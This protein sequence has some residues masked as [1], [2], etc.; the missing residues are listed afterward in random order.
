M[1]F[2]L[3]QRK[4][5]PLFGIAAA[6]VLGLA[7]FVGV[8]AAFDALNKTSNVVA[9]TVSGALYWF[10]YDVL[11]PNV[12]TASVANAGSA[13]AV[14]VLLYHGEGAASTAM[15][16]SVF[17]AQL[18]ALK[19]DGW[20]TIT[21]EQ[22]QAFM[23]HGAPLP[24]KSF[25]LT[26]DDGRKDTFYSA[27]PVLKELRYTAVMFAITGFSLP[28][29]NKN[30]TYYLS[31]SELHY[32]VGS[33]R[34]ELES[35]GDQD[36]RAYDIGN[37]NDGHFLSDKFPLASGGFE[38]TAQFDA[39]VTNDLTASKDALERTFNIPVTAFAFPFNDYGQDSVNFPDALNRLSNIVPAVYTFAFYQ[40]DTRREDPFNYGDAKTYMI[41]RIEPGNTWSGQYL[42]SLLDDN[43]PKDLPYASNGDWSSWSGNWG[44]VKTRDGALSLAASSNTTGAA[45]LLNGSRLWQN[46]TLTATV[47]W[48]RGAD[49]SLIARYQSDS[50][51]F[52][53]CAFSNNSITLEGHK[54]GVQTSLASAP[55][56]GREG[57]GVVLSM[58]VDGSS[59]ACRA[60]GAS[61]QADVSDSYLHSGDVGV[62]VWDSTPGAA[63]LDVENVSV[64][65]T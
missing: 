14:P 17:V 35:H 9:R 7:I 42:A 37:S 40:V 45:A 53:S 31:K 18:R 55:Y 5:M 64:D 38:T 57:P 41:K 52:L 1:Y 12:L 62:Q 47:A 20:N 32:M 19:A 59:V 51:T 22:F 29:D 36:H 54:N 16:E 3:S 23:K 49:A 6:I 60:S 8:N 34:W 56:T 46:Y 58:S 2:E 65:A 25:L 61:V 50:K 33:G 13:Q 39:R 44:T 24:A 15:P 43:G 27:D 63:S 48:N 11:S 30:S 28:A 4:V 10:R 21:M 26:F